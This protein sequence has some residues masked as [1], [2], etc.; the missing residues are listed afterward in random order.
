MNRGSEANGGKF[1]IIRGYFHKFRAKRTRERYEIRKIKLNENVG[2]IFCSDCER[3]ENHHCS[4]LMDTIF[5]SIENSI[6]MCIT[7][8]EIFVD[9]T[10]TLM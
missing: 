3:I 5:C 6:I 4:T 8:I 10:L 7:I 2:T 1:V 9:R